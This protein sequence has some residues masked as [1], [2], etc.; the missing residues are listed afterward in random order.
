MLRIS[1]NPP[2]VICLVEVFAK[3]NLNRDYSEILIPGYFPLFPSETSAS[4]RGVMIFIRNDLD[5]TPIPLLNNLPF[6]ESFWIEIQ[7][8]CEKI[9]LGC[10][11]RAFY[12]LDDNHKCLCKLINT[13][14]KLAKQNRLIIVG[15]FNY[16]NIDWCSYTSSENVDNPSYIFL[17]NILENNLQQHITEFTRQRGTHNPSTLDLLISNDHAVVHDIQIES[18]LGK[19]DHIVLVFNIDFAQ[20]DLTPH[21]ANYLDFKSADYSAIN[22]YFSSVPWNSLFFDQSSNECWLIFKDIVDEATSKW[23]PVKRP[24][25]KFNN[26]PQWMSRRTASAINKKKRLW[27]KYQTNPSI[28]ALNRYR[29]ARN[30]C[31]N[32]VKDSKTSFEKKIISE[33]KE[34]PKSFW[35]YIESQK[36]SKKSIPQLLKPD[37]SVTNSDKEKTEVLNNFFASVFT[38]DDP[39]IPLPHLPR[40]NFTEMRNITCTAE[41][42]LKKLNKLNSQKAPGPDKIQSY[43]LKS[44]ASS[45]AA[46]LT[47]IF[48]KSLTEGELPTDWKFAL[49]SALHKKG[50][51]KDP[52]NYRPVSLTPIVCKILESIVKEEI[53]NHLTAHNIL[54][55]QQFGF[56]PGRS[57]NSQL[58]SALDIWT[59]AINN[60]SDLDIILLDFSKAFDSVPHSRLLSKLANIGISGNTLA[61][62]RSFL[63]HRKQAVK[64]NDCTS[65]EA[66]VDSGVPQGSVLGPILFLIF[67]NDLPES[68]SSNIK[69]F[70]DDTKIFRAINSPSDADE[71]QQDLEALQHWSDLW[72]LKFNANKCVHLHVGNKFPTSYEMRNNN[73]PVTLKRSDFERDLG[74]IM[75]SKLSPSHHIDEI[76][77]KAYRALGLVKHYF[78]SL[79]EEAFVILYKAF[80][81]PVLEYNSC[82]WSPHLQKDILKIERVQKKATKCVAS[83]SQLTY[84]ERLVKLGLPTLVYRRDREDLIQVFKILSSTSNPL[85]HFF[86]YDSEQRLRGHSK[87]L[88]KAEHYRN[89][90]RQNFF[91]QRVI[92][93]WNKLPEH[94]VSVDSLNSFKSALNNLQWHSK[95]FQFP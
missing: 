45:I 1:N 84:S 32:I 27:K 66:S 87:K 11:Y 20:L 44:T 47:I 68:V 53:E 77:K 60:G 30:E 40:S 90:I 54:S 62:I 56:R 95:K 92:H 82:V 26:R 12:A 83:I 17:Q 25:D 61:W 51:R 70:A 23:V 71:L 4:S 33:F 28:Y 35:S 31:N 7:V 5:A 24:Y 19:S 85:S 89:S 15:D 14:C 81:R 10:V 8:K 64:I 2:H 94:I 55:D 46:P 21:H 52:N 65:S 41:I 37:G 58:L 48:N 79:D 59:N 69:I 63:M 9:I 57:C 78:N 6:N 86:T 73:S 72:G 36:I 38:K 22:D 80:I 67:I 50:D 42:V 75:N 3:N 43:F 93:N 34:S 16:K 29:S 88:K 39:S 49:I 74:V 18:P 76:T 13:A 91:S